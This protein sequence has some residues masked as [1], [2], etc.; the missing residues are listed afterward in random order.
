MAALGGDFAGHLTGIVA[1]FAF[2]RSAASEQLHDLN[3]SP[4]DPETFDRRP[5]RGHALATGIPKEKI[6]EYSVDQFQYV[7]T[8]R[9]NGEKQWKLNADKALSLQ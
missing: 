1:V 4:V 2:A 6:P 9:P 5:G 3:V 7:S 8:V